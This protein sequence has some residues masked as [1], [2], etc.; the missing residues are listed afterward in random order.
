MKKLMLGFLVLI[1]VVGVALGCTPKKAETIELKLA[2]LLPPTE[3]TSYGY[4]KFKELVEERSKGRLTI[5]VLGGAEAVPLFEQPE[6][7]KKGVIDL[8]WT[9]TPFLVSEIPDVMADH[10][11]LLTPM[12][13]R[14]SGYYDYMAKLYQEKGFFY[15]GRQITSYGFA[16]WTKARVDKPQNLSQVKMR[17]AKMYEAVYR[18]LGVSGVTVSPT[19]AYTALQQG[20]VAG[21]TFAPGDLIG[22]GG[23][24]LLKYQPGPMFFKSNNLVT[25]MNLAKWNS[26]PKDLQKIMLDAQKD[27]EPMM[28]DFYTKLSKKQMDLV[29]GKGIEHIEWSAADNQWFFDLLDKVTW[30]EVTSRIGADKSAQL[31]RMLTKS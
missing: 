25:V 15:L 10:L 11:S 22:F 13:E 27:L 21:V 18:G 17:A 20:L 12:E 7:A 19:E 29:L 23:T 6:A 1:L 31:K 26:L 14:K 8:T 9:A 28:V 3:E 16:F 4:V 2:G 5:K 24:E 30:E